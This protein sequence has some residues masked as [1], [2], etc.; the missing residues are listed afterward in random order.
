MKIERY[1]LIAVKLPTHAPPTPIENNVKGIIQQAEAPIA[2]RKLPMAAELWTNVFFINVYYYQARGMLKGKSVQLTAFSFLYR[3]ALNTAIRTINTAISLFAF[4]FIFAVRTLPKI[5]AI[6]GR[7]LFSCFLI[8]LWTGNC[9]LELNVSHILK[10]KARSLET[11]S[12]TL[13][14]HHN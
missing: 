1:P 3:R 10:P 13:I 11:F 5:L 14:L 4:K 8:T 2:I 9:W 6:I 12:F 7:H